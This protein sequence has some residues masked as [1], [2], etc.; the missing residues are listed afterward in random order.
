MLRGHD[1]HSDIDIW[2]QPEIL[3]L[4]Q[5]GSLTNIARAAKFHAGG[6]RGDGTLPLTSRQRVPGNLNPLPR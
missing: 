4:Y 6:Y 2:K 3:V 5:A 1:G